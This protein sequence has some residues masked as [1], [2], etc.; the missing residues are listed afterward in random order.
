M[1]YELIEWGAADGH[2]QQMLDVWD[3]D[4]EGV[5][6]RLHVFDPDDLGR[7]LAKLNEWV[8]ESLDDAQRATFALVQRFQAASVANDPELLREVLS[9]GLVSVDDRPGGLGTLDR[10]GHIER[11]ASLHE[12][13]GVGDTFA[14]RVD[15]I[16]EKGLVLRFS[17][18]RDDGSA[19]WSYAFLAIH[20]GAQWV[21][22]EHHEPEQLDAVAARF[23][24]LTAE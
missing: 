15:R 19:E 8:L 4:E 13:G 22:F 6:R 7:A 1:I 23:D 12:I 5:A 20:D 24:E 10:E 2:V 9:P 11:T 21:R 18:H 3:V 14:E 16:T 17:H